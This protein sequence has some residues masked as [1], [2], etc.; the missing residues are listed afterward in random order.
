[1][2]FSTLGLSDPLLRAI[3]EQ[4]YTSPTPIQQAAIPVVLSGQDVMA[5]AQTGTGKTASFTLP[6]LQKLSQ[7]KPARHH[8]IRALILTPTRE[9]AAQ[10]YE[11]IQ[12]Y[13]RYLSLHCAVVFGGVKIKP[14]IMTLRGGA[15]ILVATPGRLIDLYRQQ[16]IRFSDL[17]MLVLDEADSM[18]DM[19]FIKDIRTII[20]FL[21]KK[22]QTLLFSATFSSDIR[23]LAK[24]LLH[25]SVQIDIS[26]QTTTAEGI[27]QTLLEVDK[28]KKAALLIHLIG[29]QN[30]QQVLVFVRTKQGCNRL[31]K[32]LAQFGIHAAA[33]HGNKSQAARRRALADFKGNKLQVLVAT[34]IAARGIDISDLPHVINFDLPAVAQDYVHRIGRTGRAGAQ[35][36][37]LSLVSADEAS[38]LFDIEALLGK[39]IPRDNEPGFEPVHP[40]PLKKSRSTAH[41]P[42]SSGRRTGQ[43]HS[44][45]PRSPRPHGSR[46][47]THDRVRRR[48][49]SRT[50]S[51]T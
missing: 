33:I 27:R 35:G 10:V 46:Q 2:S 24:T 26:P 15:D 7:G 43:H 49:T 16:A 40:V 39:M 18:L 22:R 45:K 8:Q 47:R 32:K 29:T 6:I 20:S 37:A 11:N 13:S 50:R 14:Q 9:L 34:D 4:G 3:A 36:E 42:A 5:A 28:S 41:P 23:G 19:G 31:V 1:M 25:R 21:P 38:C 51:V 48:I 30:W 17:E 12:H 44:D